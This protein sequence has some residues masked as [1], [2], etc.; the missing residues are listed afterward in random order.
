MPLQRHACLRQ[1]A[2][3]R[4]YSPLF[5]RNSAIAVALVIYQSVVDPEMSLTENNP[6]AEPPFLNILS[7]SPI[8]P[9]AGW[10]L[11]CLYRA[12]LRPSGTP[13][14]AGWS[15]T[16]LTPRD[17]M[18]FL[19]AHVDSSGSLRRSPRLAR[20]SRNSSPRSAP[21]HLRQCRGRT[22]AA[23]LPALVELLA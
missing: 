22:R 9:P 8:S 5:V 23:C 21:R 19:R 18:I 15:A 6:G 1:S 11:T 7:D 17:R 2:A 14:A 16:Q 12:G 20:L 3:V 4:T 10:D 13:T